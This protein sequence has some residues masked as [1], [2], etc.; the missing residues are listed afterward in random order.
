MLSLIISAVFEFNFWD[1]PCSLY[2]LIFFGEHLTE[3]LSFVEVYFFGRGVQMQVDDLEKIGPNI[4]ID[5]FD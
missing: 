3:Y 4:E 5:F 1:Y 2:F